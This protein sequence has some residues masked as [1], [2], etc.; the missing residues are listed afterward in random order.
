M[1]RGVAC[2]KKNEKKFFALMINNI[3]MMMRN[4]WIYGIIRLFLFDTSK[5][6]VWLKL[7]WN[8]EITNRIL[9]FIV[10]ITGHES[11][12]FSKPCS[13]CSRV[14][15]AEKIFIWIMCT[16]KLAYMASLL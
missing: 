5:V 13:Y 6:K 10:N 4:L 15:K 3:T 1:V 16:K 2:E 8:L 9:R 14:V 12:E 11:F 7:K